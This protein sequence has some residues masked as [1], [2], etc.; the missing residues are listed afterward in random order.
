MEPGLVE[1]CVGIVVGEGNAA[2]RVAT[3]L[4]GVRLARVLVGWT[5]DVEHAGMRS[6]AQIERTL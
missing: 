3:G 6:V 1:V 2:R 4:V 5:S